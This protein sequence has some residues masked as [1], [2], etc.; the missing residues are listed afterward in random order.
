MLSNNYGFSKLINPYKE[1]CTIKFHKILIDDIRFN[2]F[3]DRFG[4]PNLLTY[5]KDEYGIVKDS[6]F[7][8]SDKAC[9][10]INF[11]KDIDDRPA[12]TIINKNEVEIK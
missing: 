12:I 3:L 1:K 11:L 7:Q 5:I 9:Y 2:E 10:S 6:Y 4:I 8:W